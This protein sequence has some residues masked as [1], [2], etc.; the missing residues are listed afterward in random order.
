MVKKMVLGFA[1]L[2]LVVASAASSYNVTFYQPVMINGSELKAGDYKVELKDKMVV[3][4][5]GKTVTEA[6]VSIQ[7]DSQKYPRTAVRLN[8][9]QVDEIRIGGTSTRIVFEKT[10]NATN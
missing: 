4:K 2:A 8:G 5:Q 9:M 10:S 1:S 3:I 6:P 7:N